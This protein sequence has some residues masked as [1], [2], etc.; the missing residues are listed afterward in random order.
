MI[1]HHIALILVEWPSVKHKWFLSSQ[2]DHNT[3][4]L[5]VSIR[6]KSFRVIEQSNNHKSC[7]VISEKWNYYI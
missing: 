1:L 2:T 6:V 5:T 7:K 4:P 3:T